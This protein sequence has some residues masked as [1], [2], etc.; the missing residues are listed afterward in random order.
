MSAREIAII[1][2]PG[3][4]EDNIRNLVYALEAEGNLPFPVYVSTAKLTP[5]GKG[6][7]F[8]WIETLMK[9]CAEQGWGDDLKAHMQYSA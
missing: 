8:E 5:I 3:A 9:I 2:A 4:N 7:V 1:S 6:D